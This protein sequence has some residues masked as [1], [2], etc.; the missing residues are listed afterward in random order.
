MISLWA[1]HADRVKGGV[2]IRPGQTYSIDCVWGCCGSGDF[3]IDGH[4]I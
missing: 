3:E 1:L 2:Q 4:P